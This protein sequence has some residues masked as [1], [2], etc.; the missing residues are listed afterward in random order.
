[1][2]NQDQNPF[3]LPLR[4]RQWCDPVYTHSLPRSPGKQVS[5]TSSCCQTACFAS[6]RHLTQLWH[7]L[8]PVPICQ[9]YFQ[10]FAHF[11]VNNFVN[12]WDHFPTY[13]F[14]TDGT[15][16]ARPWCTIQTCSFCLSSIE[17]LVQVLNSCPAPLAC[18][19]SA[20][21]P[22]FNCS[23]H[24]LDASLGRFMAKCSCFNF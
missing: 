10:R 3:V 8:M 13:C 16:W 12:I 9:Q 20:Y 7:Y 18:S 15:L 19:R 4:L 21:W 6:P 11:G 14:R 23:S 22:V 24:R 2:A 5:L 1:M 17:M